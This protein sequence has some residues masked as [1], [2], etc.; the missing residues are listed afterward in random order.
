MPSDKWTRGP[1]VIGGV[2]YEGVTAPGTAHNVF[3]SI[4]GVGKERN[5]SV[6]RDY[7][8]ICFLALKLSVFLLCTR[9][10]HHRLDPDHH[11]HQ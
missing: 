7:L 5:L 4:S 11:L 6:D 1:L 9:A 8:L 10:L 2:S 3:P